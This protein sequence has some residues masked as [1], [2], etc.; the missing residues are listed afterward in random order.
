MYAIK[1]QP[2]ISDVKL[3]LAI[4]IIYKYGS[5]LYLIDNNMM[6]LCVYEHHS[7]NYE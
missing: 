3:L 6:K 7:Y 5:E 4:I 1:A 2:S